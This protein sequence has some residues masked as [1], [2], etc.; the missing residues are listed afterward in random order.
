MSHGR[1]K[2]LPHLA[3][4]FIGRATD[5]A[6]GLLDEKLVTGIPS[7]GVAAGRVRGPLFRAQDCRASHPALLASTLQAEFLGM[8]NDLV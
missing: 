6:F 4:S 8:L 1:T 2:H 3:H 7:R 5:A